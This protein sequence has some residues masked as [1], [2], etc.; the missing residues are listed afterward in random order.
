MAKRT[1]IREV[2]MQWTAW[3]DTMSAERLIMMRL[4]C[5]KEKIDVNDETAVKQ[6]WQQEMD[7]T[8][9]TLRLVDEDIKNLHLQLRGMQARR[10]RLREMLGLPPTGRSK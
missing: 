9:S 1:S 3:L 8:R 5:D 2:P 7:N 4:I 6:R 10:K